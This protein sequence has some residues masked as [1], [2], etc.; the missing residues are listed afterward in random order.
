[1]ARTPQ[2]NE[3]FFRE[4]DDEVRREQFATA[5]RRY[6]VIFAVVVVLA[7]VA[8]GGCLW[9]RSHREAVAGER[10]DQLIAA[11][12]SL[13][14][15]QEADANKGLQALAGTGDKGYAPLARMLQ[16]DILVKDGKLPEASARR[17]RR[18]PATP[19]CRSSCAIVATAARDR[20]RFRQDPPQSV[21]IAS[22][23]WRWRA[24]RGSAAPAR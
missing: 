15:G 5:A 4:V 3:A 23:R 19:R 9:W 24:I 7:L 17:S 6:G 12:A 22:S 11:M 2:N 1:M 18:S 21:S 20:A 14:S 10:G 13:S 8:L 16:A